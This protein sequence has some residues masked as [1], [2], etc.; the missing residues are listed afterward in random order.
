MHE[1]KP[2]PCCGFALLFFSGVRAA[3]TQELTLW[4]TKMLSL[5]KHVKTSGFYCHLITIF[6]S[7]SKFLTVFV[8]FL[9]QTAFTSAP[10]LAQI[11]QLYG[12]DGLT[13][14]ALNENKGD[15]QNKYRTHSFCIIEAAP[16]ARKN[17]D[18]CLCVSSFQKSSLLLL[19]V[20]WPF[21]F[22]PFLSAS[23]KFFFA[24]ASLSLHLESVS[25]V[26]FVSL[27]SLGFWPHSCQG[28]DHTVVTDT[29]SPRYVFEA[30]LSALAPHPS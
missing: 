11:Q 24:S 26:S 29:T 5:S 25:L 16:G 23:F 22:S 19:Q 20:K 14:E 15:W 7:P 6:M 13:I 21:S 30:L 8:F 10:V 17:H 2:G 28:S 3:T 27:S 12:F 1:P 4:C 9:D 18:V